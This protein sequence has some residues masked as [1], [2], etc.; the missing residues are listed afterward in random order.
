MHSVWR[1]YLCFPVNSHNC[2]IILSI[3]KL[4][5]SI[6]NA[7]VDGNVVSCTCN[8]L[9]SCCSSSVK[10]KLRDTYYIHCVSVFVEPL[11]FFWYWYHVF[12]CGIFSNS[13]CNHINRL[14]PPYFSKILFISSVLSDLLSYIFITIFWLIHFS[15]VISQFIIFL[16]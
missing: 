5:K 3:I 6:S 16:V 1:W 7:F 2:S 13:L 10:L 4:E 15:E 8:F 9:C 14:L 11:F 12:S